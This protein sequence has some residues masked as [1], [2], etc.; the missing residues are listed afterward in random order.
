MGFETWQDILIWVVIGVT[1]LFGAPIIELIKQGLS[2]LFKKPIK[3]K[4]AVA[5]AVA[6]AAGISLL[7]LWLSGQ[8][9]SWPL[10]IDNFPE[11][12]GVVFSMATVYFKLFMS[13]E[14]K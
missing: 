11:F 6:V 5:V 13:G 4:A 14:K 9:N 10:T 12:F 3:D 7:E 2:A 8:L 1:F